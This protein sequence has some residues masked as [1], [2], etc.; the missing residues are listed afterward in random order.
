MHDKGDSAKC[1]ERHEE[2]VIGNWKKGGPYYIVAKYFAESCPKDAWK[3]DIV[4]NE[5]T[6]LTKDV[7]NQMFKV[8]LDFFLSLIVKS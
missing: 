4:N 1:S 7:S 8:Q 2:Y 5:L 3:A 6:Y